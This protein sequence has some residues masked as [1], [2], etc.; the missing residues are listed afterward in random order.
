M[1]ILRESQEQGGG[2]RREQRRE[3][4]RKR[5]RARRLRSIAMLPSM[6]TLGNLICGFAAIHFAAMY[7][8]GR[9]MAVESQLLPSHLAI[10]GYLI[11]LAMFFDA[12]DGQLA[13]LARQSSEFGAQLDSLADVVS[14]GVA[15]AFMMICLLSHTWEAEFIGPASPKFWGRLAW[16]LAAVYVACAG[17]R[18]ARFNVENVVENEAH[19]AFRGLP[20]PAA[21][22]AVVSLIV[23]HED[24]LRVFQDS[25]RN[26]LKVASTALVWALPWVTAGLGLL[27]VS[28]I[29]YTHL[30]NVYVRGHRPFTHLVAAV[31]LLAVFLQWPQLTLAAL[32][33]GFTLSG[34]ILVLVQRARG[35]TTQPGHASATPSQSEDDREQQSA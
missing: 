28:R 9:P 4:R 1:R 8:A 33:I 18:L 23:L 31:F 3:Q 13:R 12:I 6:A 34:P 27:M 30:M 26:E 15:P 29:R 14:F 19:K 7:L 2:Q 10:A 25:E 5:R 32:A 11:F 21:G 20:S 35:K 16:V 17:L 22:F 24:V